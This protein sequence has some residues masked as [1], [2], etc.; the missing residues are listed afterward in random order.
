[1]ASPHDPLPLLRTMDIPDL[2]YNLRG[3]KLKYL[4]ILLLITIQL[5]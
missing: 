1:M 2:L 5:L 4:N 3:E